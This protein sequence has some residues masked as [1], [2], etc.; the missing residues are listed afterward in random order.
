MGYN[1][2]PV[3]VQG[4]NQSVATFAQSN[5]AH[6]HEHFFSSLEAHATFRTPIQET[7]HCEPQFY[8]CSQ[9]LSGNSH[10]GWKNIVCTDEKQ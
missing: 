5:L 7:A 1:M 2:L 8:Q 4:D 9:L 3:I 10:F 6:K